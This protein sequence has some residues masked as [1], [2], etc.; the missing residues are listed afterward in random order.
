MTEPN[1]WNEWGK[2]VLAELERLNAELAALRRDFN[3]LQHKFV[4]AEVKLAMIGGVAG[5]VMAGA[6]S[7]VLK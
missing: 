2:H 4:A 7:M 3:Q 6:I 5:M 1:G